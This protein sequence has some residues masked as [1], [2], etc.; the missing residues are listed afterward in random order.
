M[1]F[2]CGAL[3]IFCFVFSDFYNVEMAEK[4]NLYAVCGLSGCFGKRLDFIFLS[5]FLK[6]TVDLFLKTF[7]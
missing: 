4:I 1:G 5:S 6:E 3:F 7:Y 2:R